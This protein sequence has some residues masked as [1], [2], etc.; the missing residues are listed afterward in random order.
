MPAPLPG[1]QTTPGFQT[2]FPTPWGP[3]QMAPPLWWDFPTNYADLT[4]NEEEEWVEEPPEKK[5]K[6]FELDTE[7]PNSWQLSEEQT[8]HMMKHMRHFSAEEIKVLKEQCPKPE[9][10]FLQPRKMDKEMWGLISNKNALEQAKDVDGSLR[11]VFMAAADVMGPLGK[12]WTELD[13]CRIQASEG[14]EPDCDL[15]SVLTGLEQSSLMMAHLLFL[16]EH[17]RRLPSLWFFPKI[18]KFL[19]S[20]LGKQRT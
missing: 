14:Q 10:D 7:D 12:T 16:I 18:S 13:R 6:M 8:Q 19:H 1:F 2:G 20:F 15:N 9:A 5:Y 11:A 17:K 4:A 3:M